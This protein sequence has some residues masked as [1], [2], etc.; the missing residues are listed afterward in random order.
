M[1]TLDR[2]TITLKEICDK[3][4][5]NGENP[6]YAPALERAKQMPGI[7][8]DLPNEKCPKCRGLKYLT[9]DF[10]LGEFKSLLATNRFR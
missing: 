3:C 2:F 7:H 6:E 9:R 1:N 5:G 8:T 10:S 4:D